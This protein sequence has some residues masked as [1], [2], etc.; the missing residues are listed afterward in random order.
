MFINL[1]AQDDRRLLAVFGPSESPGAN[2]TPSNLLA[3]DSHPD[4]ER[5]RDAARTGRLAR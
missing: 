5:L 2:T 1:S 3:D 4:E